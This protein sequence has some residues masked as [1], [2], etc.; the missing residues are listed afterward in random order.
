MR[1]RGEKEALISGAVIALASGGGVA[2]SITNGGVGALIG[3][4]ISASLLPP[5]VNTGMLFA[6]TIVNPDD[7]EVEA[8]LLSLALFVVNV[9]CIMMSG[10]SP[11]FITSFHRVFLICD[12]PSSYVL[13]QNQGHWPQH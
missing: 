12:L 10:K 2:L 11:L 9:F 8:A 4:A 1:Q 6:L 7:F 5:V 3:V 13:L